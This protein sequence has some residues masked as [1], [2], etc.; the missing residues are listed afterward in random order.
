[1]YLL[2]FILNIDGSY[3]KVHIAD[4]LCD[5]DRYRICH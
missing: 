2:E 3:V 5:C 4:G 1:M